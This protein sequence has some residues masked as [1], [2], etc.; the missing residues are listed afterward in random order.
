LGCNY[1]ELLQE[2]RTK[3]ITASGV[4]FS[5][6]AVG[7]CTKMGLNVEEARLEDLHIP[8]GRYRTVVLSH[9]LEHIA[10]PVGLLTRVAASLPYNGT[11]VICVPNLTSPVRTIFGAHWHGWDPPFHLVHYDE[12]SLRRVCELSGLSVVQVIK[13]VIPEDFRRSMLLWRGHKGRYLLFRILCIPATYI[14]TLLGFGSYLLVT[15]RPAGSAG[16][17]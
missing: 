1:G 7:Y 11:I 4:E 2:L 17:H 9:V 5:P 13:R 16:A 8:S 6:T 15:A 10:D 3:G 12:T 14:L